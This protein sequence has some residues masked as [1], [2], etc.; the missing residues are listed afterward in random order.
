[1]RAYDHRTRLFT[2]GASRSRLKTISLKS[3][4]M[5]FAQ[6]ADTS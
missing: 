4:A 3:F 1:M 5:Y 6:Y 2:S